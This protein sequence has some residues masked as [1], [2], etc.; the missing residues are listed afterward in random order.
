VCVCVFVCAY[1]CF[2]LFQ[3]VCMFASELSREQL[4][5]EQ[6]YSGQNV[7]KEPYFGWAL[8]TKDKKR[9]LPRKRRN[10]KIDA[11]YVNKKTMDDERD[12]VTLTSFFNRI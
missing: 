1:V 10:D 12:V 6:K 3:G 8:L 9:D 2:L 11:G 5:Q 4:S 7:Q